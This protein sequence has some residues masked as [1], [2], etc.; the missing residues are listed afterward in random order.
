MGDVA[1][2]EQNEP[3]EQIIQEALDW[4]ESHDSAGQVTLYEKVLAAALRSAREE[5]LKFG[6]YAHF[7]CGHVVGKPWPKP[8]CPICAEIAAAYARAEAAEAKLREA[9][10]REAGER[11]GENAESL[12]FL[13]GRAD[14]RTIRD[15]T[16]MLERRMAL[17]PNPEGGRG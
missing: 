4:V 16:R 8:V 5:L 1:M 14:D 7:P 13:L 6:L 3:T 2:T 17:K 9:E 12:L 11:V 10:A 15:F